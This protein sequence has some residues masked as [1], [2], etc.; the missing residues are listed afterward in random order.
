MTRLTIGLSTPVILTVSVAIFAAI[1][2]AFSAGFEARV[3]LTLVWMVIVIGLYTFIGNS[4]IVS[5][6]H[7]AFMAIGAYAY[8]LMTIPPMVKRTILPELPTVMQDLDVP[9]LPATILAGLIAA[10]FAVVISPLV[11]RLSGIAAAIALFAVLT[12]VNVVIGEAEAITRGHAVLT[13]IPFSTGLGG[14]LGWGVVAICSA[15]WFQ[16]SRS[17]LRLRASREDEFAARAA[18]VSIPRERIRALIVSGFFVG[19][20]GALFAGLLG[21]ISPTA[22]FIGVTFT[23]LA[24]LVIGG[25]RS[26]TGA[27][28]G[29]ATVFVGTE[30]LRRAEKGFDI[31]ALHV[32]PRAG[33][34]LLGVAALGLIVLLVRPRGLTGGREVSLRP[35]QGARAAGALSGLAGMLRRGRPE[36]RP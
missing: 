32:P 21:S 36:R 16:N 22:F 2:S 28:L 35:G 1:G 7:I 8:G 30:L 3:S 11:R 29:T 12:I 14:T 25:M 13:G 23:T 9:T 17:G 5:F 26:L 20:G 6:G 33:L 4:G 19:V 31:S 18:G 27:V 34:Q 10:V 15:W 24:M